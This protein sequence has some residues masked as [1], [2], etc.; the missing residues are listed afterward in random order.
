[1]RDTW[2][3]SLGWEDTLEKEMAT[4]SSILAWRIP[5][6][7]EPGRLQSTGSQRV[8][9][10]WATSPSPSRSPMFLKTPLSIEISTSFSKWLTPSGRVSGSFILQV[11]LTSWVGPSCCYTRTLLQF[12]EGTGWGWGSASPWPSQLALSERNLYNGAGARVIRVLVLSVSYNWCRTW[13]GAPSPRSFFL[14]IELL[15]QWAS[16]WEILL[17][18]CHSWGEIIAQTVHFRERRPLSSLLHMPRIWKLKEQM[19]ADMS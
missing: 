15:Q 17:A 4:H 7:E 19:V 18:T 11:C 9:H 13:Q 2:V 1:M 8:R 10:D 3:W 5:W 16:V 6:T 12:Y 14:G